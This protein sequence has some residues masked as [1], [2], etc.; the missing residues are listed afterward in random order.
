[1][2]N[3]HSYINAKATG[4]K[5]YERELGRK[6]TV[7]EIQRVLLEWYGIYFRF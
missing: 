6:A 3:I 4:I 2:R 1:M 7:I 5:R